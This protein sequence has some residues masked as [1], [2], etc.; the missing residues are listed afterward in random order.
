MK[1]QMLLTAMLTAGLVLGTSVSA[2]GHGGPGFHGGE[3]NLAAKLERMADRLGLSDAQLEQIQTIAD[4]SLDGSLRDSL[5]ANREALREASAF[6]SYD[7]ERVAELAATQGELMSQALIKRS[8]VK[9]EILG[10]LTAAQRDELASLRAERQAR[11]E[12][13]RERF[14]NRRG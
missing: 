7:A 14:R 6:E 4:A 9:H 8:E 10:V 11:R 1:K 12:Q 3:V 13:R 2:R 5:A